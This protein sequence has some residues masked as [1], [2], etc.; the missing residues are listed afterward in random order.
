[1]TDYETELKFDLIQIELDK[2]NKQIDNATK[3]RHELLEKLKE[4]IKNS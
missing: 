4:H 1:M 3:E 2:L